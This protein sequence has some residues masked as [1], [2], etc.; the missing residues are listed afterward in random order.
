MRSIYF[1]FVYPHILHGVEIY[2]NTFSTYL[3]ALNVLNNKLLRNLQ[4]C[5]LQTP[6]DDVIAAVQALPDKCCTLDPL[7]TSLLN[8]VVDVVTPFL[9]TLFNLS[10]S[11]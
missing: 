5:Q 7:P 2:A 1:A 8:V 10:L 4:N 11:L 3:K 6:D 9:S